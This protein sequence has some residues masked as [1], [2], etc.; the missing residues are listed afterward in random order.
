M[1]NAITNSCDAYTKFHTHY[2]KARAAAETTL[3][4]VLSISAPLA[5]CVQ[6]QGK[7]A[8]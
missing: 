5:A 4:N 6:E 7:L 1:Q 2:Q 8:R 3:A